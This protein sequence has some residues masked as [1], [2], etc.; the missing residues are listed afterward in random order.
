MKINE[1]T[2]EVISLEEAVAYTHG[3]QNKYPNEP[4]AFFVGKQKVKRI[5]A[6]ENCM[7]IRIYNG[8]DAKTKSTNLVLVGVD[9][10]G[11]DISQGVILQELV[12]CPV[13]CSESSPLIK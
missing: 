9:E 3:Y 7:G 10:K 2:A 12:G 6:Q 5:L 11:E 13:D 1:N 4:K 8:Y